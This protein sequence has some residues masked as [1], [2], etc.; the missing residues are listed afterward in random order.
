M[1]THN[2]QGDTTERDDGTYKGKHEKPSELRQC[3]GGNPTQSGA[4]G[5]AYFSLPSRCFGINRQSWVWSADSGQYN[6]DIYNLATIQEGY[7]FVLGNLNTRNGAY[8]YV[9]AESH[10]TWTTWSIWKV[11]TCTMNC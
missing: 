3:L 11:G 7:P 9:K 4:M 5:R 10:M 6:Y 2:R 8:A 1:F